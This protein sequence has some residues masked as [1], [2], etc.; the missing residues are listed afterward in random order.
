VGAMNEK[1]R[2]NAQ[3]YRGNNIHKDKYSKEARRIKDIDKFGYHVSDHAVI[4]YL[5]RVMNQPVERYRYERIVPIDKGNEVSNWHE[6]YDKYIK[7]NNY[8]LVIKNQTVVTVLPPKG[9]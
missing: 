7:L 9:G 8:Q 6:G 4:R 2:R 5:D 3:G 1:D